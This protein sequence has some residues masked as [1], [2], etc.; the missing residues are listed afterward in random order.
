MY[1]WVKALARNGYSVFYVFYFIVCHFVMENLQTHS[2]SL[3]MTHCVDLIYD[4]GFQCYFSFAK[5][6]TF[7]FVL[8]RQLSS[9]SRIRLHR[10]LF[11]SLLFHAIISAL[12]K[13]HLLQT[14]FD[15]TPDD[16][17]FAHTPAASS[18]NSVYSLRMPSMCLVLSVLLRYFRSTNYLW[19]FN[20]VFVHN[21][22]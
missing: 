13:W 18:S 6:L 12:L 22:C 7:I 9:M 1:A 4:D 17:E 11:T 5:C 14:T 21:Y 8:V 3:T 19:M 10:H 16:H 2:V 15:R 20:E